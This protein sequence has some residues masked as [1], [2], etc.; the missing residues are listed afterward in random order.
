MPRLL[1]YQSIK[2]FESKIQMAL[3]N[4]IMFKIIDKLNFL[5]DNKFCQN[6]MMNSL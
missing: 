4:R 5:G 3:L 2:H 1:Q 6:Q